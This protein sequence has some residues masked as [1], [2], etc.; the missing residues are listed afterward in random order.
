MA[1]PVPQRI[2]ESPDEQLSAAQI[3]TL[4][5]IDFMRGMLAGRLPAAP[6]ARLAG[7]RLAE[8]RE[9][10]VVFEAE[11]RFEHYNPIGS[12]HGGWF[13]I[14]LDSA[15]ACAVMT[16]L[17][18]GTGYTTLEYKMNILRPV[19]E[20]TGRLRAVGRSVHAGRRTATAEG[21]LEDGAGRLYATGT[22]TCMVMELA[23]Q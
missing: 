4:S 18:R 1:E 22:T 11:P 10:E 16:R 13:G 20:S 15:M 19:F 17:P 9:G 12:V 23:R 6:I 14:L 2:P 21:R 5:G 8:V 7:M 3:A